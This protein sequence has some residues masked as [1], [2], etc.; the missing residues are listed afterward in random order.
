MSENDQ[1]VSERK[2]FEKWQN[3]KDVY[4]M[5][6]WDIWLAATA[7]EREACATLCANMPTY[8]NGIQCAL[9]IRMR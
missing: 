8:S 5:T 9:K 2:A 3:G 4:L 7:A 6:A 1:W